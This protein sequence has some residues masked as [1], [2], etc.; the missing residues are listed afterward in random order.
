MTNATNITCY[1]DND[2]RLCGYACGSDIRSATAEER[3]A[4]KAAGAEGA[5]EASV[6]LRTLRTAAKRSVNA[7][8]FEGYL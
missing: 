8:A 4:S 6:S 2:G 3:R 7:R 5:F 1:V